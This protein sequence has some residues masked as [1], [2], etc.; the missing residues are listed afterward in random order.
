MRAVP[1]H[2]T[3]REMMKRTR[4]EIG[5]ALKAKIALEARLPEA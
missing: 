4:R 1:S 2:R 3:E 5:A